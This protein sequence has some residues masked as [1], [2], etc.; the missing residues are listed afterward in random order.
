MAYR[1]VNGRPYNV[2]PISTEQSYAQG[3]KESLKNSSN[4]SFKSYLDNE[5]R[6][7]NGYRVS[8]HAE[9]RI[10]A[11]AL[12]DAD[13]NKLNEGLNMAEKKGSKNTVIL[14]K[15]VAFIASVE[16]RTLITAV[17]KERAKDNIYTNIDSLVIL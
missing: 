10:K 17:N 11:L 13:L 6:K 16:N 3:S 14:Y 8:T 4:C 2:E 12:S 15:D 5:I 1:I 7:N 9:E